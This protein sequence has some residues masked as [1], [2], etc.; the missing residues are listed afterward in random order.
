MWTAGT[1]ATVEITS[2]GGNPI[3]QLTNLTWK[4]NTN[5]NEWFGVYQIEVYSNGAYHT[6]R[7]GG[8]AFYLPMDGSSQIGIDQSG[9]NDFTPVNFGGSVELDKATGA[10]PILNLVVAELS[11]D[12]GCLVVM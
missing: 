4:A 2:L 3:T 8:N 5:N 7:Q 9:K 10:R 1:T 6:L 12:L 11:Q